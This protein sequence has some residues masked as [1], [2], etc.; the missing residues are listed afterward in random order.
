[1]VPILFP[2]CIK[3][4]LLFFLRLNP[5][6]IK[7]WLSG[8]SRHL[9]SV[10]PVEMAIFWLLLWMQLVQG[11]HVGVWRVSNNESLTNLAFHSV[12]K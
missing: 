4:F 9:P 11:E 12:L 1:M 7:L 10:L 2:F 5:A 8:L 3:L 6:G